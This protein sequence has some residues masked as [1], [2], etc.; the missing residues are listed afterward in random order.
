MSHFLLNE[1]SNSNAQVNQ[2]RV[3]EK[4]ISLHDQ[5]ILNEIMKKKPKKKKKRPIFISSEFFEKEK[6]PEEE[7]KMETKENASKIKTKTSFLNNERI[8]EELVRKYI[9]SKLRSV[10][11]A[12]I[13][14]QRL[15]KLF[16][17]N[18]V[19]R[20]S[21]KK[22]PDLS[23]FAQVFSVLLIRSPMTPTPFTFCFASFT[24]RISSK[25]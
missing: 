4:P 23:Q 3:Q 25:W 5:M 16:R 1:S 14:I 22:N 9:T 15:S 18:Q 12:V 2:P 6:D 17:F 7:I 8:N 21:S 11:I 13:F 20:L 19:L 24:Q 10:F